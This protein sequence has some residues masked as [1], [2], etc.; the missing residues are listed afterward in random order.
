M[1][2]LSFLSRGY[3]QC[4]GGLLYA[5]LGLKRRKQNT[6]QGGIA[7][8]NPQLRF[9]HQPN[10]GTFFKKILARTKQWLLLNVDFSY[11]IPGRY[12]QERLNH[13][14]FAF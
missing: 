10:C 6:L 4:G 1:I 7:E 5:E 11:I 3:W 9:P 8:S 13:Q 2:V 14:F 12:H